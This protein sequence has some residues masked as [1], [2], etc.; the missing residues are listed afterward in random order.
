MTIVSFF[1][2]IQSHGV[3]H[4]YANWGVNVEPEVD[5]F[6]RRMGILT[7]VYNHL[8]FAIF[9]ETAWL[10]YPL[11]LVKHFYRTSIVQLLHLGMKNKVRSHHDLALL[12]QHSKLVHFVLRL[13]PVFISEFVKEKDAMFPGID[14][15]A[16]FIGTVIHALDHATFERA[17]ADAL[18]LD[19]THPRF[20]EMARLCAV[21]RVGF[22]EEL[23]CLLTKIK[24]CDGPR[25]YRR[26]FD[27]AM[28]IDG[29][30]AGDLDACIAR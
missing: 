3:V 5:S 24:L 7:V 16:L 1:A 26:I 20:G 2:M 30:L 13:R 10:F 11:G 15:E 25:F 14:G 29:Q 9:R 28:L 17:L 8:G 18:W 19:T 21:L 23:P 22:L 27:A 4:A 6:V 12:D